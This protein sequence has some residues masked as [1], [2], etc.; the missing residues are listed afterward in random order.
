MILDKLNFDLDIIDTGFSKI[1]GFSKNQ[2]I[3]S[4]SLQKSDYQELNELYLIIEE[5]VLD[6]LRV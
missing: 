5:G 1:D 4:L 2:P 3:M 6:S